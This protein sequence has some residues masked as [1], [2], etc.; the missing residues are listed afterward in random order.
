MRLNFYEA[1]NFLPHNNI[2][3]YY[4][5]YNTIM[6]PRLLLSNYRITEITRLV[7]VEVAHYC[8][9]RFDFNST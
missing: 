6:A 9:N 8:S 2:Y 5:Y 1:S 4:F 7:V 3:D